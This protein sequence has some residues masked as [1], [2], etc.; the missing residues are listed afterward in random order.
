MRTARFGGHHDVSTGEGVS[1]HSLPGPMSGVGGGVPTTRRDLVPEIS[2]SSGTEWLTDTCENVTFR[3]LCWRA[4]KSHD[5][6]RFP[7]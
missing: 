1:A 6:S 5:C 3:Q 4:V 2:T 7:F